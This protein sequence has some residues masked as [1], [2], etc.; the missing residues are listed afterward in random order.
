[1]HV[2]PP[3][4]TILDGGDRGEDVPPDVHHEGYQE[5][6]EEVQEVQEGVQVE[7]DLECL[8]EV[9]ALVRGR[10][11]RTGKVRIVEASAA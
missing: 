7:G 10:K 8:V 3:S 11:G 6:Q 2:D 5:V 9:L 1:M 4:L